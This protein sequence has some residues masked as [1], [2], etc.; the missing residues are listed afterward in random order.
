MTE[1]IAVGWARPG[2][3]SE[4]VLGIQKSERG[5]RFER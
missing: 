3:L 1:R 2:V 4:V 5:R